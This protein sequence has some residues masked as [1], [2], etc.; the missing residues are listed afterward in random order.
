MVASK[1]PER[2]Y[3]ELLRGTAILDAE[4]GEDRNYLQSGGYS[5]ILESAEDLIRLKEAI[6]YERRPCE[7][8]TRIGKDT[9]FSSVLYITNDDFSIVVY[10]PISILPTTILNELED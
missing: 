10:M 4:Y 1:L 7:W 2:V 9:G 6:D 3:T 8:A 5:L